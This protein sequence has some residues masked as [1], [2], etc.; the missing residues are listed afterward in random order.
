MTKQEVVAGKHLI[1]EVM[2]SVMLENIHYGVIPGCKVPSLYKAGSEAILT[3][4]RIA[5]VPEVIDHSTR[6]CFRYLVKCHGL[7]PSGIEVGVGIGEASTDEEK[8]MW[9]GAVCPEE[10]EATTEDRRR[11]KWQKGWNNSPAK[12]VQ[13]VRTNPADLANTVLKMAKKRAQIDLTLTATGA[14]DVFAQ[15]LEDLTDE[16]RESLL[17]EQQTPTTGKPAVVQPTQN[18]P[19]T[20]VATSGG[21][22]VT[23]SQIKMLNI[24]LKNAG[25]TPESFCKHY[26]ISDVSNL[27]MSEM[28]PALKALGNGDIHNI[29]SD[30]VPAPAASETTPETIEVVPVEICK[31]CG[32]EIDDDNNGHLSDCPNGEA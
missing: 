7:L 26:N 2:S 19:V 20:P 14:S 15:D 27:S 6:D 24:K 31:N 16:L 3:T 23:E 12:A 29:Q 8:Y 25:I 9:R 32:R 13:Q 5:V 4:F 10:F 28:N 11:I 1:K 17:G 21:K 22:T 18:K 30:P